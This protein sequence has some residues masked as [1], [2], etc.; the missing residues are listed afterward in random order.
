M[1]DSFTLSPV[2]AFDVFGDR[3]L[4]LQDGWPAA[5][6]PGLYRWIHLDLTR[7]PSHRWVTEHLPEIAAGAL[8]QSETRPRFDADEKGSVVN[9]RGVN[10]NAGSQAEDM[11]SLRLWVTEGC[12]VSARL[13][14]VFAVDD[15]R[16]EFEAGTPPGSIG[17]FLVRLAR[18]LTD[19]IETVSLALEDAVDA[20]EEGGPGDIVQL[21]QKVIKLRRYVGPQ[22]EA[23]EDMAQTGHRV[24]DPLRRGRMR[25]IANRASR[26]VEELDATRDRLVALQDHQE[27]LAQARLA[28]NNYLLAIVAAIFLPLGFLTG[29]FGVN[30]GGMPGAEA[31]WAFGVLTLGLAALGGGLVLL[32]K[33]LRWF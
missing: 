33:F 11:V 2:C 3:A 9:L 31:D 4:P 20:L 8:L 25:E 16:R 26:I 10:M 23:L 17:G 12:I 22:R 5:T 14:K 24:F 13:R 6:G 27:A 28:R 7:A 30:V 29:L 15:L 21:R 19:R 32:F 18:G 1:T